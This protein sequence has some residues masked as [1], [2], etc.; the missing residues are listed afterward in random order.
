MGNTPGTDEQHFPGYDVLDQS[1]KWDEVT[2]GVVLARLAPVGPLR[3]FTAAQEPTARSLVDRLLAQDGE[4]RVPVIEMIDQRLL[5][6]RGD[7]YRYKEMP[8][9]WEAWPRSVEGLDADAREQEGR[10]FFD[11][12]RGDQ[13]ELID[14]VRR[15]EGDWHGMPGGRLFELWMRYACDAFYSHPWAWNEIGFGGPAYPRGYKN[16]GL[17][18]REPWEVAERDPVDPVTGNETSRPTRP[19]R[20]RA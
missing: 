18:R 10:P 15:F 6:R 7:G 12:E 8:E 19:Q 4:P 14:R 2:R 5:E 9:D 11:L 1:G 3:F 20:V 13:S 16:L 17:G